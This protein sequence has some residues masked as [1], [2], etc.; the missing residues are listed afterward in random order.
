MGQ[1]S[2]EER[3]KMLPDAKPKMVDAWVKFNGRVDNHRRQ[4][5]DLTGG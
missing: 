2:T 5:F 3:T 4:L 1:N